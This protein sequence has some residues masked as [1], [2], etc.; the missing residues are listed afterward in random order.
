MSFF[1]PKTNKKMKVKVKTTSLIDKNG[2]G[3]NLIP[4]LYIGYESYGYCRV[5]A[6]YFS[7]FFWELM[8]EF[9]FKY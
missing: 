9:H 6:F 1:R 2:F 5:G 7:W 3:I 8:I 4:V